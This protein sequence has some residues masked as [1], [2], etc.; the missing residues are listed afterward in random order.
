MHFLRIE[1]IA[2]ANDDGYLWGSV[3]VDVETGVEY[4]VF[5]YS[6]RAIAVQPRYGPDGKV[7]VASQWEIE[8]AMQAHTQAQQARKDAESEAKMRSTPRYI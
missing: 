4:F 1:G 3:Y 8:R 6:D 7:V 5:R 2:G